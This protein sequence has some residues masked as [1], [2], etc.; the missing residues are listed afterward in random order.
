M[1]LFSLIGIIAVFFSCSVL[2][3]QATQTDNKFTLKFINTG[4]YH[5]TGFYLNRGNDS[6]N[7]S[8]NVLPVAMLDSL[9]YVFIG[10]LAKGSDYAMRARFDSAGTTAYLIF[11]HMATTGPDTIS[12]H[13][14]LE[15]LGYS[16]G[17][18]WGLQI[19]PGE[20]KLGQ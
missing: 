9:Q 2:G 18:A 15:P 14:A 17:Y 19:W 20:V 5:I 8:Q 7:W 13:A 4:T 6:I 10:N 1:R 12:A 11:T 3:P 16:I